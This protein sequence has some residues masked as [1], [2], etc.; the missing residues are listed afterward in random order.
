[1]DALQRKEYPG[2]LDALP[3][4]QAVDVLN[5]RMKHVSQLNAHI[6][7]WL[8]ERRR[9]EEA[10]VQGLRKLANKRPPDESS[11]LGVF[12]TPWQKIV[13]A[14]EAVAESHHTLAQ[15][16]EVD[17]ERPLREFSA[18]NREV[19]GMSTISGNLASMARE[20]DTA[21]KKAEKLR[22]KGT[23]AKASAVAGAV[24]DVENATLQWESQAPYVFEKLQAV[25]ESRLNHLRDAL[26]QFQTHE[27]DQVERNRIS[28]EETLN[29]LLNIETADEIQTW[30]LRARSGEKPPPASRKG[31]SVGTP[32]RSLAPPPMPP[33]PT[34]Q[35][36]DNRS[37]KSGSEEKGKHS[38]NPLKRFG[39]VLNRRRQSMH[40]YGRQASPE[41]KSNS[42]L[43]SGF[44]GF[45]KIKSK[46]RDTAGSSIDRPGSSATAT[47]PRPSDVSG[48]PKHTRK[49]SAD[50]PNGTSPEPFEERAASPIPA[51]AAVNGTTHDTIPELVE[52]LSPPVQEEAQPEPEKDAEGFSVPPSAI[53]AITQ[54]EHEAREAGSSATELNPP[55]QFKLDIK[56]APIQEEEGD[57]NAAMAV[58]ANTLRAQAAPARRSG[59]LR[60]RRDVRNT[61][62]VPNPATPDLTSIGEVPPIP[63]ASSENTTFS[64]PALPPQP[65]SPVFKLPHR[66]LASDDHPASDTQSIRSGRS[67][68]SS[69]STT[70]KHPDMHEPGLNASLVET[71]S[72]WF[73]QG[74]VTKSLVIGQVALAFNPVDITSGPFGTENIRLE[75]FPVLEKVA[76]NPAFVEQ[77]I[78]TPGEY[79]VDLSRITK[80][81][82]AFHYQVHLESENLAS[83]APILLSPVWKTEST[84]ISV[85]LNYGLNP[86][87]NI[88]DQNSVTLQNLVLVLRL[89]PGSKATAC[90]SKP[91]GTFSREKGLIYWRLGE[92]TFSRDQPS[93]SMRVRF[94]T[95]GEA[96]PGNSEARW[97]IT[98]AHSL[99]LGSGL[100]V[101]QVVPGESKPEEKEADPF[102]DAEENVP[103][104]ASPAPTSKPVFSVKRISSGTY[105]G[106]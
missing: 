26:T 79:T 42:N 14:T 73:E 43:G 94:F 71:V 32:S 4:Q 45:G 21:K 18:T 36:D 16:I 8:Q 28:A 49:S 95:E 35:A 75:N 46:D 98:G 103:P 93:Q 13:S 10:Y 83:F 100:A 17:V 97:E 66:T 47:T 5:G 7:D 101:S 92:V 23:K 51:P 64:P 88:G 39:T 67:L 20:I 2:L 53:D 15:K 29:V 41:R 22:E 3:P 54:A 25:D 62:F 91:A 104:P 11:D 57:V 27:V 37:Q 82:V 78:D 99:T 87:F 50:R 74:H 19:Q 33:P 59:T 77:V 44:P 40:P 61:I 70:M 24:A 81:S 69:T 60:G 52:P 85:L 80:T 89:E 1:M 63:S 38:S 86:K 106:V 68:S 55:P 65:A 34:I 6:A 96:K 12:S 84:Q 102:A 31:S 72:A 56:N 9:V 76:P 105:L 30:A 58:M 90:Q 48:S